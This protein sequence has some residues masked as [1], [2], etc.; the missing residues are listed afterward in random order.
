MLPFT[1]RKAPMRSG[2]SSKPSRI[3]SA[4]RSSGG[5]SGITES[6]GKDG[7]TRSPRGRD[8]GLAVADHDRERQGSPCS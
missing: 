8:V 1:G 4:P 6:Y 5:Y 3:A 7:N 2:R